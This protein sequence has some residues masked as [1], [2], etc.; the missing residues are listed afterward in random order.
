[1]MGDDRYMGPGVCFG[2]FGEEFDAG[3]D[4]LM[5]KRAFLLIVLI[6]V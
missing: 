5:E 4:F 1:M 6:L 2:G 3:L